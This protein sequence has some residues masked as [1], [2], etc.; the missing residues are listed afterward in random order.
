MMVC[1]VMMLLTHVALEQARAVIESHLLCVHRFRQRIVQ[2]GVQRGAH[3]YWEDDPGFDL[4]WHVRRIALPAP[5]GNAELAEI[6]S[7]LISTA[8]DPNKPMWQF[9]VIDGADGTDGHSALVLR[10]HH[11]YGDGYALAH[12]INALTDADP[13]SAPAARQD[14]SELPANHSGWE[15]MLGPR[16]ESVTDIVRLGWSLAGTAGDWIA[17]PSRAIGLVLRQATELASDSVD[18]LGELALIANMK[19]DSPNRLKGKL[20]VMKKVAWA[21]PESLLEVQA[22][23]AAHACSVN[24]VLLCCVAGALRDYLVANG[25]VVDALDV[26]AMVPV[27]LR[28]PGLIA[29]LGNRFGLFIVSLPLEGDDPITRLLE[30]RKRM[31]A[32]KRSSQAR[33][34]LAVLAAI[35]LAPDAMREKALLTLAANASVVISNVKGAPDVRYFA[36]QRIARQLFWVPQ[37]GGIGLGISLLSYAGQVNFGVVTDVR[38]VPDPEQLANRF[39][40]QFEALL[41]ATLMLDP[42]QRPQA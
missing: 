20:G 24:D 14:I 11:C 36:G 7:D 32:L 19:P 37:S 2:R 5:A 13:Q 15:R 3:R 22:V 12:V 40:A 30:V 6:I 31:R 26:R 33:A 21:E 18:L 10:I 25:E 41:L 42:P 8:L 38:R 35:A 16:T 4:H 29:E 23:A 34:T 17:H 39:H 28:A 9:H 27:N 1:A